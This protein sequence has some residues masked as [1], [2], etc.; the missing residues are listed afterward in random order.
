MGTAEAKCHFLKFNRVRAGSLNAF[1][2]STGRSTDT[3][4]HIYVS[5]YI[6]IQL[7]HRKNKTQKHS[8]GRLYSPIKRIIC[9]YHKHWLLNNCL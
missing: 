3:L 6:G 1:Q 5:A 2:K 8:L 4:I 7:A 9:S